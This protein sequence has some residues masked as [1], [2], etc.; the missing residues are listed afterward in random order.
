MVPKLA[1]YRY[2]GPK[3]AGYRYL[4]PKLAGYRDL[5]P[6]L[7]GNRDLGPKLAGYRDWGPPLPPPHIGPGIIPWYSRLRS[8]FQIL[9]REFTGG[10]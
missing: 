6:K 3:L 4:G 8:F 9:N 10:V 1:G 7:A 5:G 2:L